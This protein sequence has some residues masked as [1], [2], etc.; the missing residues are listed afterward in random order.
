MIAIDIKL[1][2]ARDAAKKLLA[3]G[4]PASV[5]AAIKTHLKQSLLLE[6]MGET[7]RSDRIV[8]FCRAAKVIDPLELAVALGDRARVGLGY[9]FANGTGADISRALEG[10]I[11]DGVLDLSVAEIAELPAQVGA[12]AKVVELESVE[13]SPAHVARDR[14][15]H[16]IAR[17]PQSVGEPALEDP[18]RR[19]QAPAD[20]ARARPQSLF[21]VPDAGPRDVDAPPSRH[22]QRAIRRARGPH[23]HADEIGGLTE[24]ETFAYRYQIIE[25]LPDSLFTLR[26][27]TELDLMTCTLP[28]EIPRQ[29]AELTSL[30]TL[31]LSYSTWASR[32]AELR[33]LLPECAISATR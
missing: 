9:L 25:R 13:Q 8:A 30:R 29:F 26:K 16:E 3:L 15:R 23:R 1:K 27:L 11:V 17:A 32:A 31:E 19:R 7:K 12:L 33:R 4:A 5:N 10:R 24:L 28:A 21:S 6:S 18:G 14:A 2:K 20:E 22:L